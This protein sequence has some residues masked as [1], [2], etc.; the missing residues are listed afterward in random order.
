ME[1]SSTVVEFGRAGSNLRTVKKKFVTPA[2][3]KAA[4][5]KLINEKLNKD[6]GNNDENA[7]VPFQWTC[8]VNDAMEDAFGNPVPERRSDAFTENLKC[9]GNRVTHRVEVICEL[10]PNNRDVQVTMRAVTYRDRDVN[11]QCDLSN[12]SQ[13][14]I[15]FIV[16]HNER[17]GARLFVEETQA[18]LSNGGEHD[19]TVAWFG[20]S[21][22]STPNSSDCWGIDSACAFVPLQPQPSDDPAGL[23]PEAG[24]EIKQGIWN[25]AAL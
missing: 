5:E 13:E 6:I 21:R 25:I 12:R 3:A 10:L 1:G 8:F 2:A 7:D 20:V 22:P 16:H 23:P 9:Q 18:N 4:M 17:V 11:G 15:T 14:S 24:G 19:Q